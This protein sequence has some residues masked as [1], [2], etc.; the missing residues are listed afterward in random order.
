MIAQRRKMCEELAGASGLNVWSYRFDT[1]PWNASVWDG[2]QHF[3]N[4]A[5]SFQNISGSLGPVPQYE[6]YGK[7]SRGIGEAYVSFVN[8]RDPNG[9][10]RNASLPFWPKWTDGERVNMVLNSNGSFAEKDDFRE[11]GIDFINSI[12]RELWA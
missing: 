11:E 12:D 9:S 3:V 10:G 8:G 1:P 7:L 6:S 5:F 4:V 2:V